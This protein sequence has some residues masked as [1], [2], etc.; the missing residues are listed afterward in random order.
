MKWITREHIRVDRVAC[1]WLIRKFVDPEPAFLF[2]PFE[3]VIDV[4]G[5]EGAIFGNSADARPTTIF[6]DMSL[7]ALGVNPSLTIS[8]L[9]LRI[10]DK[11]IQELPPVPTNP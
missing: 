10:A 6:P 9:S 3:R 8:A 2:I 5:R 11:M 7:E 4:V 1:P